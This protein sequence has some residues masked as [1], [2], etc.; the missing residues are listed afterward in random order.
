MNFNKLSIKLLNQLSQSPQSKNRLVETINEIIDNECKDIKD[1]VNEEVIQELKKYVKDEYNLFAS[2]K[3]AQS[4][5]EKYEAI[6]NTLS[7]FSFKYSYAQIKQIIYLITLDKI[8]TMDNKPVFYKLYLLLT[9]IT[10][11]IEALHHY[12]NLDNAP[13][14][15]KGIARTPHPKVKNAIK[16]RIK[17][18]SEALKYNNTPSNQ[19]QLKLYDEFEKNPNEIMLMYFGNNIFG[20][21]VYDNKNSELINTIF[22]HQAFLNSGVK[23]EDYHIFTSCQISTINIYK[24][25]SLPNI[26]LQLFD[27][28]N[29]K[30]LANT[31]NSLTKVFFD[32]LFTKNITTKSFT[33]PNEIKTYFNNTPILQYTTK[34]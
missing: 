8:V 32:D 14:E 33:K 31:F 3:L 9:T 23:L 17:H 4:K 19:T 29:Y 12:N 13:I 34:A 5:Q 21:D 11:H 28:I 27:K 2:K 24:K 1:I 16:P 26:Q 15:N 10:Q 7:Q 20:K 30:K 6:K 18:N 22:N 25:N